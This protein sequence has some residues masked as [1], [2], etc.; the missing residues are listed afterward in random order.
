MFSGLS[1]HDGSLVIMEIS[2][3]PWFVGCQFH[4]E[5]KSRPNRAHPL[6]RDFFRGGGFKK[7][8]KQVNIIRGGTLEGG[9]T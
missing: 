7:G 3:H 8:G 5:F 1:P 2:E 6:F 4:P 9:L